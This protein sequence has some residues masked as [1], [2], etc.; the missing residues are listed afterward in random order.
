MEEKYIEKEKCIPE[1]L[2]EECETCGNLW[3]SQECDVCE[4]FDMYKEGE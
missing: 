1:W 2:Y 4:G 3:S